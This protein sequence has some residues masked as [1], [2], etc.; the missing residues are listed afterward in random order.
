[1]H[2]RCRLKHHH[3]RTSIIFERVW[4]QTYTW[5]FG[6]EAPLTIYKAATVQDGNDIYMVGG[7]YEGHPLTPYYGILIFDG[8]S[9]AWSV[10]EE[11]LATKRY[12]HVAMLVDEDDY[13]CWSRITRNLFVLTMKLM[14][15][16][17]RPTC[18]TRPTRLI[19]ITGPPAFTLLNADA[20]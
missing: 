18:L 3:T 16:P 15:F 4:F 11:K 7:S 5:S 6:P 8:E 9:Y 2:H 14:S 20:L 1:M 17:T 19:R 12:G 10:L 13:F